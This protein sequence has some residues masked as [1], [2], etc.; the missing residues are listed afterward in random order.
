MAKTERK[1]DPTDRKGEPPGERGHGSKLP[2]DGW[3]GE[4][5]RLSRPGKSPEEGP[6]QAP[7][8]PIS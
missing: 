5:K 3:F 7:R 6:K 2:V 4:P 1:N 8:P